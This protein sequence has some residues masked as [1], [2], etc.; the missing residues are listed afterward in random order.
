MQILCFFFFFLSKGSSNVWLFH[1]AVLFRFY[2]LLVVVHFIWTNK[3]DDDD[4]LK[5]YCAL[6][7]S[8]N[9]AIHT[10][11]GMT[12]TPGK[13]HNT[14]NK[15]FSKLSVPC[16]KTPTVTFTSVFVLIMRTSLF[17]NVR[18]SSLINTIH[19]VIYYVVRCNGRQWLAWILN[20]LF[21]SLLY[22]S[23]SKFVYFV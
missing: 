1:L 6:L 10:V 18:T 20:C 3:D 11:Q 22:C 7:C 15:Y 5:C 14:I 23:F 9:N 19:Q 13:C 17:V 2:H 4:K 16:P 21:L 8:R 12:F